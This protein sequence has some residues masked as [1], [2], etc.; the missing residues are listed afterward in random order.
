MN[1]SQSTSLHNASPK[2]HFYQRIERY[3][4]SRRDLRG[5]AW[6][7]MKQRFYVV[8]QIYG[9]KNQCNLT[10]LHKELLCLDISFLPVYFCLESLESRC[11]GPGGAEL[12]RTMWESEEETARVVFSLQFLLWLRK[13]LHLYRPFHT[14]TSSINV[15]RLEST[16]CTESRAWPQRWRLEITSVTAVKD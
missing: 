13:K 16:F 1:Y 10:A 5:P 15:D 14:S 9:E 11:G 2:T 7:D 6:H 3:W 4:Q 8:C 12:E